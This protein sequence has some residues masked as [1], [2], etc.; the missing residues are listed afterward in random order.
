MVELLHSGVRGAKRSSPRVSWERNAIF[1]HASQSLGHRSNLDFSCHLLDHWARPELIINS[2]S[3]C[4][5]ELRQKKG[6]N[7]ENFSERN[8]GQ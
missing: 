1:V 3:L 4:K 2:C 8:G 6:K 7:Y 5:G